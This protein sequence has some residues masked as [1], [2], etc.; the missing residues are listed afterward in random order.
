MLREWDACW[1]GGL[2]GLVQL[3]QHAAA[4]ALEGE[5]K[6]VSPYSWLIGYDFF[7][8]KTVYLK[9]ERVWNYC[10]TEFTVI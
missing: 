1:L 6:A 9:L 5:T 2:A 4:Q 7:V 3:L 10:E 8:L